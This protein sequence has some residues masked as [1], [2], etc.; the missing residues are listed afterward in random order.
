MELDK[1]QAAEWMLETFGDR[2]QTR[3]GP[4]GRWR[5]DGEPIE[6]L[7]IWMTA[8][9]PYVETGEV[10]FSFPQNQPDMYDVLGKLRRLRVERGR[11]FAE[12]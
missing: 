9:Y 10:S 8:V 12:R 4:K 6:A 3:P 1:D 11:S 5:W 2:L 7:A